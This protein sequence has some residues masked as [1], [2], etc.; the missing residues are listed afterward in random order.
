MVLLP[1]LG[2]FFA[3]LQ[4]SQIGGVAWIRRVG[5]GMPALHAPLL[6]FEL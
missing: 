6:A 5:W 3:I 2:S 4:H 1:F